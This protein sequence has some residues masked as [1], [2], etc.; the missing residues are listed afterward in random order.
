MANMGLWQVA[1]RYTFAVTRLALGSVFLWAFVDKLIGLDHA[2]PAA[3]AW[4]NGGSPST[5]F[6]SGVEGPFAGFFQSI[7]GPAADWLFMVGL[8]G[9][10]S[11]LMLGIGMRIAAASGALM[12]VL[13][14][15]AVLP[16]VNHPFIDDHLVYAAVLVGLALT[17][18]GDALGL[19][20]VWAKL[21]F[22]RKFPV[23]V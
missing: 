18:A 7:T 12:L 9:I 10:G 16:I 3:K 5:G 2:T 17:H 15:A 22:V 6:L 14:W 20:R 13:M 8:L 23:L 19:G 4:L 21:P 1:A 11:A